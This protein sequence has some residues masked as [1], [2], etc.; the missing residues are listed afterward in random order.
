MTKNYF[1][2]FLIKIL[3]ISGLLLT[4][5]TLLL[6][7]FNLSYGIKHLV[8]LVTMF[9][10]INYAAHYF[11]IKNSELKPSKFIRTF[12]VVSVI[13]ILIYISILIIYILT[14][15]SG[16]K[17]FLLTFLLTYLSFTIF[18]VIELSKFLKNNSVK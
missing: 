14:L 9:L 5:G 18:E 10:M 7:I 13:K 3:V 2:R 8:F 11:F 1:S 4:I 6:N 16:L 15:V 17:L 12:M